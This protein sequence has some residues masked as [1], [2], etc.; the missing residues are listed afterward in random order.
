MSQTLIPVLLAVP[1]AAAAVTWLARPP[2]VLYAVGAAA[3]VTILA[4]AITLLTGVVGGAEPHAFGRWLVLDH[5]G[6]VVLLIVATVGFTSAVY[7]IGYLHHEL[8][9]RAVGRGELRRYF[10][11]LHVFVFTMLLSALAGNLG[12]LWTAIAGTTIVSAPLVDFYGS[13]EPLEAAWKYIVLTTAGSMVALL[14]YLVLYQAGVHVLGVSYDFSFSVLSA[15]APRLPAATAAT[16][17]L[18]VLV[19]FGAKAGLA[20]MHTWLPD[21]HSQAPSPVCALLSGVELNCAMLGILRAFALT[22]P[23]A[24]AGRLR[25]ALLAFGVLSMLVAVVF[26]V[27]QRDFKRLL[28]Y[29]SIEQMGLVAVGVGAGVPLAVSGAMLQMVNHAFSKSLMFFATGNLLLRFRTRA[30]GSVAGLVHDMPATA[31]LLIVGVLALAGAPPFSLFVS[32]FSIVSGAAVAHQWAPALIVAALLAVGFLALVWPFNR[33]AFSAPPGS[34]GQGTT[35]N[36]IVLLPAYLSLVVVV[37]L[38]F[39]VP[40]PLHALLSGAARTLAP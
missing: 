40:S 24:G 29:S 9:E 38:G 1:L 19:G 39:W 11:L 6:G 10:A 31:I 35:V 33:M 32:E 5:L 34:A 27:S 12:L 14:G 21:A 13:R 30:I 8:T 4:L 37:G 26:L 25:L 15:V 23:A 7:S 22:A 2:A 18:L 3:H 17:F 36:P 16:A 20:P 28:A